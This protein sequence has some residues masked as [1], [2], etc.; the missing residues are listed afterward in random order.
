MSFRVTVLEKDVPV[1]Y[2]SE[3]KLAHC[4]DCRGFAS[5]A[6]SLKVYR[7]TQPADPIV[8]FS[9]SRWAYSVSR[10]S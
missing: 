3:E 4:S 7:S 10:V 8:M 9:S 1:K 6:I 5:N 2:G